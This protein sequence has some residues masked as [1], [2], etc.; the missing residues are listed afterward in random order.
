[1]KKSYILIFLIMIV[2]LTGCASESTKH[3]EEASGVNQDDEISQD[4][5]EIDDE[6]EENNENKG[7]KESEDTDYDK[8]VEKDIHLNETFEVEDK[9]EFTLQSV[10]LT[11]RIDPPHQDGFYTYYEVKDDDLIYLDVVID[12]EN[13]GKRARGADN[14]MDVRVMYEER[15]EYYGFS[16]IEENDGSDFSY[17]NITSI[18][19][20]KNR[21]LHYIIELP[22]VVE[23]N[24]ED[25]K[26]IIDTEKNEH[27][28]YIY[29][30]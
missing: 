13:I 24:A 21:T 5:E 26:V 2:L 23:D 12:V 7:Q 22:N 3:T 9:Y 17:T 30:D 6:D 29:E 18:D 27:Y 25:I 20:L 14:F 19:P 15:Y 10:D 28:H 4:R 1:M 8:Y 11:T 16:I